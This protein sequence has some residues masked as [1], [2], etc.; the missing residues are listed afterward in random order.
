MFWLYWGTIKKETSPVENTDTFFV[1][2]KCDLMLKDG[3]RIVLDI[4]TNHK[5]AN[6][7]Y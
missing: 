6:Y 1:D 2:C 7:L 3:Q 5:V 4:F